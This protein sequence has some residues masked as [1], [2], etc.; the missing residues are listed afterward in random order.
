M[1]AC[2][3]LHVPARRPKVGLHHLAGGTCNSGAKLAN[4]NCQQ[5]NA[6][7]CGLCA[8]CAPHSSSKEG[9]TQLEPQWVPFERQAASAHLMLLLHICSCHFEVLQYFCSPIT[10][11]VF[12][13]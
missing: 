2:K 5:A 4:A 6:N 10:Q 7:C 3:L 9:L 12:L 8:L 13:V 1:R 11:L